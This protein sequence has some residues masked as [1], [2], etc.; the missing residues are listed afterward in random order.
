MMKCL[1]PHNLN[2]V[3]WTRNYLEPLKWLLLYKDSLLHEYLIGYFLMSWN[4][5][6]PFTPKKSDKKPLQIHFKQK[7]NPSDDQMATV[8]RTSVSVL[9]MGQTFSRY[10]FNQSRRFSRTRIL[11]CRVVTWYLCGFE[12]ETNTKKRDSMLQILLLQEYK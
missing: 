5:S 2:F 6:K 10:I 9:S 4:K 1:W 8:S 11:P 3:G 7:T 12:R